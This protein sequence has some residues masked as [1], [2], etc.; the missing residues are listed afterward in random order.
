MSFNNAPSKNQLSPKARGLAQQIN[1]VGGCLVHHRETDSWT[2]RGEE[3][4]Q[5]AAHELWLLAAL[6]TI[7]DLGYEVRY[8]L[9]SEGRRL[10]VRPNYESVI[11]KSFNRKHQ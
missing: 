8:E 11:L 2:M 9:S 3:V 7:T 10:L 5:K 1:R 6:Q 4:N